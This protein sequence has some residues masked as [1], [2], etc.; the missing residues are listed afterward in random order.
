MACCGA[1]SV[2]V[3]LNTIYKPS[4]A[5]TIYY[6]CIKLEFSPELQALQ[7][8][9]QQG[10]TKLRLCCLFSMLYNFKYICRS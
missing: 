10:T 7:A 5:F 6:I 8:V 2:Y 1:Q 4:Q 9:E 3:I